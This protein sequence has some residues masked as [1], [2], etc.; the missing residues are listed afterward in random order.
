MPPIAEVKIGGVATY[1]KVVQ[2]VS[3]TL[4]AF[5][6]CHGLR[7]IWSFGIIRQSYGSYSNRISDLDFPFQDGGVG[8]NP[9]G[10]HLGHQD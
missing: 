1:R 8:E 10:F 4:A 6:A 2:P 5:S 9:P 7:K 3:Q